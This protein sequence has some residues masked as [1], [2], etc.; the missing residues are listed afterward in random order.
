M[1][2]SLVSVAA[3]MPSLA[4]DVCC[5]ELLQAHVGAP[6]YEHRLLNVFNMFG[7]FSLLSM[8]SMFNVFS[9]FNEKR[10]VNH[11]QL[12]SS[13]LQT[14]LDFLW[15]T[16]ALVVCRA[17]YGTSIPDRRRFAPS[18]LRRMGQPIETVSAR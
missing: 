11:L 18:H 1:A 8:F 6:E 5:V 14:Q 10:P 17:R 3:A 9:M 15:P 13:T 12:Q 7:V 2:M 4:P 16:R